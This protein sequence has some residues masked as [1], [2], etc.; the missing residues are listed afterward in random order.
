M[1]SER[2][3]PGAVSPGLGQG[4]LHPPPGGDGT[5]ASRGHAALLLSSGLKGQREVVPYGTLCFHHEAKDGRV[6]I[7]VG[8][9]ARG[10]RAEKPARPGDKGTHPHG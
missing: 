6:E 3:G 2:I 1:A 5:G 8:K 4:L 10:P 7:I 9:S